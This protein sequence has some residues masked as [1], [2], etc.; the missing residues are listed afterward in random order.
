M[1]WFAHLFKRSKTESI[2]FVDVGAASVAGGYV[3]FSEKS[4]PKMVYTKRVEINIGTDESH[5]K[6]MARSL[7]TLSEILIREGAPAL[8]RAVGHGNISS[9]VV[10]ISAPWQKTI[11][12]T[13]RFEDKKTFTFTRR[14]LAEAVKNST[15]TPKGKMLVDESVI[16]VMLNGYEIP[17]PIG[18]TVHRATVIVLTSFIDESV[19]RLIAVALGNLF[20]TKQVLSIAGSSL[21]Y[22]ALRTA[23]KHERN[24][25]V[26]D[27]SGPEIVISLIRKGR[28]RAITEAKSSG[29]GDSGWVQDVTKNLAEIAKRFPLPRTIFLI[30]EPNKTS[31]IKE[32]LDK[33]NLGNLWLTEAPPKIVTVLPSH[34]ALIQTGTEA[35]PDLP[36]LLMA[37]YWS[38]HGQDDI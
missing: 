27:A 6:A 15:V 14:I 21:R 33:A 37:L 19:A 36:L 17:D 8:F 34:I 1:S 3:H 38:E 28:L 26:L 16:A 22:Q 5:E 9:V 30:T 29:E 12:R 32:T 4:A 20:H 13:E 2:V 25:L 23:F 31:V 7:A 10:S 18:K 11:M 24:A 35:S